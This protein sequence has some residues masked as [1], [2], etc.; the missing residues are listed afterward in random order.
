MTEEKVHGIK[1]Y[2]LGLFGMS[3]LTID[4]HAAA[5]EIMFWCQVGAAIGGLILIVR[6]VRRDI[7]KHGW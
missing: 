4:V 6:Q 7:K 1:N 5:S 2:I 3:A